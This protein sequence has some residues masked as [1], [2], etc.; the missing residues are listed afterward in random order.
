[1]SII[2]NNIPA[3]TATVFDLPLTG[4]ENQVMFRA[5]NWGA[6]Q[7]RVE[8]YS[9]SDGAAKALNTFVAAADIDWCPPCLSD[10][11]AYRFTVMTPDI[12]TTD[13][14]VEILEPGCC[15]GSTTTDCFEIPI[16]FVPCNTGV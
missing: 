14:Y 13:L 2:Y 11:Q 5:S 10:G 16:K 15:C 6:T 7:V 1:M 4:C 12:V 8:S 9:T 3:N